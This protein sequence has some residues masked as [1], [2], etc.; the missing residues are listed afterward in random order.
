MLSHHINCVDQT[1]S[2]IALARAANLPV[3]YVIGLGTTPGAV[4]HGWAQVC[5]NNIFVVS[6][7]TNTVIFG[8]WETSQGYYKD[9]TYSL[10][11]SNGNNALNGLTDE[12]TYYFT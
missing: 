9:Y 12:N 2:F 6:D 11:V 1:S 7:P 10:L 4:G 8:D 3:R 5:I